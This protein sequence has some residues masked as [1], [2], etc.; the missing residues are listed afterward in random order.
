MTISSVGLSRHQLH[1]TKPITI[2]VAEAKRLSAIALSQHV[3]F[4]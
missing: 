2:T 4:G 1:G 3:P